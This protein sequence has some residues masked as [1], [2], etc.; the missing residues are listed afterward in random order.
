MN[1]FIRFFSFLC[2]ASLVVFMLALFGVLGSA[3]APAFKTF[4]F[5]FF[6]TEV[7]NP[8][9]EKFGALAAIYGTLVTS[10]LA[11]LLVLPVSFGIAFFLVEIAPRPLV[12][13]LRIAIELLA[14]IPSIVYGFWGLF[15]LAPLFQERV[16]PFLISLFADVPLLN[17]LFQGPGFGVG[18]LTA[19]CVLAIMILP[20]LTAL[21]T[22]IFK[23]VMPILKESAFALGATRWEVMRSIVVSSTKA[24][25]AGSIMLAFGRALGETMAVTF[26]IGNAH[27]LSSSLLAPG[28]TISASIAN[29]FNEATGN[30]HTASLLALGLTL[31]AITFFVLACGKAMMMFLN[32]Q[33]TTP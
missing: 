10:V 11:L 19:G 1:Q 33:E 29:E 2:A 23:T 5:S 20:I 25:V 31:F 12:K 16:Q 26:V 21:F 7:W 14:G 22:D 27:R 30:L 3:A 13:P 8:V 9:T 17:S 24:S 32:R 15:V 4:G 28:T 6:S 18:L